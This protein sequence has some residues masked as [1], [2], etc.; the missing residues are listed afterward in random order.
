[1]SHL[2]I[3]PVT[4]KDNVGLSVTVALPATPVLTTADAKTAMRVDFSED[5][6]FINALIESATLYVQKIL[7]RALISQ[8][9]IA[10]WDSV[11]ADVPLPYVAKESI[12][13]VSAVVTIDDEGTETALVLNTGYFVR[14][15]KL[16]VGTNLGLRATY[17]AG[18]GAA[19]TDVP[20]PIIT[21]IERIVLGLYDRR[22]DEIL[23]NNIDQLAMNSMVLLSPYINHETY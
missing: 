20:R 3:K 7:N 14:N 21:A 12:T 13:S 2:S 9:V 23:E 11:G 17:T 19:S 8:T 10:E 6:T 16:K 18:Y 5:E 1:M 22:D 15:G 4:R